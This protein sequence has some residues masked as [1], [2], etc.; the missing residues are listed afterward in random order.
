MGETT[1]TEHCVN[2]AGGFTLSQI[3]TIL[4]VVVDRNAPEKRACA[5]ERAGACV[6]AYVYVRVRAY[7]CV[8]VCVRVCACVRVWERAGASVRA[9]VCVRACA[10]MCLCVCACVALRSGTRERY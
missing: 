1:P 4:Y 3:N 10:R 2:G 9:Y 8:R 7:V 5:R 6:R